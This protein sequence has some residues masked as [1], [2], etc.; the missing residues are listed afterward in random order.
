M[1]IVEKRIEDLDIFEKDAFERAGLAILTVAE[2]ILAQSN[3]RFILLPE[4][5][6][7]ARMVNLLQWQAG[8]HVE[9]LD[10]EGVF[11]DQVVHMAIHQ[12]LDREQGSATPHHMLFAEVLASA[13]DMYLAGR[14]IQAGEETDFLADTL[15]SL[16]S[17]YEMYAA[18]PDQ[19]TAFLQRLSDTP[20]ET[21]VSLV[22][23]LYTFCCP[24]LEKDRSIE[25]LSIPRSMEDHMFYPL[26]H[27]YNVTNWLLTIN[28]TFPKSSGQV[29]NL[30]MARNLLLSNEVSFLETLKRWGSD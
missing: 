1:K 9:Y 5:R 2:H 23:Y 29:P 21:M 12:A 24:F 20:W 30:D 7:L 28:A 15:E 3:T 11:S 10:G 14:L 16:G 18:S 4:S 6:G 26:V 8:D 27:H 22:D 25:H 17:Y 19:L 13:S